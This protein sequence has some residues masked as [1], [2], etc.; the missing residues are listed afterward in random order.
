MTMKN[1]LF[2][3]P[4][5]LFACMGGISD[6]K[7]PGKC[8]EDFQLTYHLNGGMRYYSEDL[9]ISIDSCIYKEINDGELII[10]NFKLS[11]E[12]MDKL[13]AQLRDN[14]FDYIESTNEGIV[15]DRGG[16]S[17]VVTWDKS[18]K[19]IAVSNSGSDFIKPKWKKQ[20][21]IIVQYL[22]NLI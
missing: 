14:K 11:K 9:F 12:E 4:A 15:H 13:Y 7:L 17:I 19:A 16:V 10:K 18:Q 2:S 3:L 22:K 21:E 6:S 8:P 1:L 20:W 5:I